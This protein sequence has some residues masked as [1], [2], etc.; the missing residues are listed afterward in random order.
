MLLI[1]IDHFKGFNDR[2]GHAAGDEMLKPIT[3]EIMAAAR[4]TDFTYR[5]GGEEFVV[6]A[7]GIAGDDAF[8]LGERI[9]RSVA[10]APSDD[11]AG[12]VTASIGV[13]TCASDASG[14]DKLFEIAD[15]RLYEAKAAGRNRVIG[16]RA[17]NGD[18]AVRLVAG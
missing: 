4:I 9:R 14:Y 17:P 13:A 2:F 8:A 16:A 6:I 12:R 5:F 10:A 11:P 3:R 7:D 18:G 15:K 1:D